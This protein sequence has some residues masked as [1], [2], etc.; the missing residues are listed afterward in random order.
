MEPPPAPGRCVPCRGVPDGPLAGNGD[1][2]LVIGGNRGALG[3][4]TDQPAPFRP[5]GLGLYFGKND[6]WGFPDAVTFH[7]SFQHFSVGYL[8]VSVLDQELP[9]F[10][11]RQRLSDARLSAT[12]SSSGST[13]VTVEAAVLVQNVVLVN[14]SAACP[15][16]SS[17]V[18]L[19]LK[20]GSDNPFDLPMSVFS[21]PYS[22]HGQQGQPEGPGG[23]LL[24]LTK[25]SVRRSGLFSPVLTPC[26]AGQMAFNGL[27][28]FMVD[29]VTGRLSVVNQTDGGSRLCLRLV[30]AD[31]SDV[32]LKK[33]P[34]DVRGKQVMTAACDDHP[35][36]RWVFEA[37]RIRLRLT[38][39]DGH[40]KQ[41]SGGST[42]DGRIA[43]GRD[44]GDGDVDVCFV[45]R[46]N[47]DDVSCPP[48]SYDTEASSTG[49]CQ[50]RRWTLQPEACGGT[51]AEPKW[52]Y[53]RLSGFV[54]SLSPSAEGRCL[55]SVGPVESNNV[56]VVVRLL[57]S[58]A[59]EALEATVG[60]TRFGGGAGERAVP[61]A[62][63]A[64]SI[65]SVC[66]SPIRLAIAVVTQRDAAELY[67]LE[68]DASPSKLLRLAERLAS[69][70]VSGAKEAR[71]PH[72][73]R[74]AVIHAE[75]NEDGDLGE[76]EL[77]SRHS[78]W[79]S[80]FYCRSWIDLGGPTG[81]LADLERFYI[82]M[83]YLIRGR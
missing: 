36:S 61:S 38:C 23:T 78:T 72:Q 8:L 50:S 37:G 40:R 71:H 32:D 68:P 17:A 43:A 64:T 48:G 44:C 18:T 33:R 42:Y 10:T 65:R 69:V 5:S 35:L 76:M 27:R 22:P 6:F 9:R 82:S 66:G 81:K 51:S 25:S 59:V 29:V 46:D 57:S 56:A 31:G 4:P 80:D 54:S 49:A 16:P 70:R 2:G 60:G 52:S 73:E 1:L 3:L 58:E 20:L 12:A 11:A 47:G 7:A 55:T 83:L 77:L 30:E 45:V 24:S 74:D 26:N 34:F 14:L 41:T 63:A 21:T 53:D 67:G 13:S 62:E 28:T 75:P 19:Q 79:W 15:S 39:I